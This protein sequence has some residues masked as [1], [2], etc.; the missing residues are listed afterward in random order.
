[1]KVPPRRHLRARATAGRGRQRGGRTCGPRATTCGRSTCRSTRGIP[2]W[3]TG[4]TRWRSRCPCTPRPASP[5]TSPRASTSPFGSSVSTPS[6]APTSPRPVGVGRVPLPARDLLPPLER[7]A[8]PRDRRR[9]RSSSARSWRRTGARTGAATVRCPSCSTA[10]SAASTRTRSSPTSRSSS[11]PVHATSRSATPTSSTRHRTRAASSPRMHE[12]FPDVTFDC[13]VKVE[14]VLRYA[15]ALARVR[16]G[17]LRVRGVGVRVGR[18]RG[19]RTARQGPHHA[20]TPP[21]RSRSCATR[22]SRCGPSWLPFTPWTTRDDVVALLDFVARA[23]PRRQ[24]RPGAVQRAAARSPR[25]RCCSTTPTS[26]PFLGPWDPERSTYTWAHPDPA[27]DD[28]QQRIAAIVDSDDDPIELYARVREAA[29]ALPV[30]LTRI[31][32]GRPRLSESWFCCAEPTELQL[33]AIT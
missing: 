7:Y 25:A 1:M 15:D 5:A 28:L 3:S 2:R 19:A 20:P 32:T 29:G 4:P 12:R 23:R 26:C 14:H 33:R 21:A 13:T 24:R 30:D 11:P 6:S 10:A 9:Q 8:R 17:R 18:R 31:T 22:A 27:V 16:R